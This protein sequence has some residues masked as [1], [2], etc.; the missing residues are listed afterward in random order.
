MSDP[1]IAEIAAIF[2][3]RTLFGSLELPANKPELA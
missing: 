1:A 2:R 3:S